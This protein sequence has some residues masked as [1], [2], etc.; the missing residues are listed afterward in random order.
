MRSPSMQSVEMEKLR[1]DLVRRRGAF[2]PQVR[3]ILGSGR[4]LYMR[5][6]RGQLNPWDVALDRYWEYFKTSCIEEVVDRVERAIGNLMAT[7]P[8]ALGDAEPHGT[9]SLEE[10]SGPRAG[11]PPS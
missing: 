1:R 6:G 4:V 7:S 10:R 5:F 8:P 9:A 11:G 3:R 2:K